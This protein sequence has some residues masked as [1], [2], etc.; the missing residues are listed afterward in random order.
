MNPVFDESFLKRFNTLA[1]PLA[2][3]W[4]MSTL[5]GIFLSKAPVEGA[6]ERFETF[7]ELFRFGDKFGIVTQTAGASHGKTVTTTTLVPSGH[8]VKAIY[9]S[10]F[11]S[12]VSI[13]DGKETTVVPLHGRYKKDFTLIGIS[14]S[15]AVFSGFGKSYRL[16]LGFEDNLARRKTVSVMVEETAADT[17]ESEWR[18]VSRE[19]LV[20]QM[21]NMNRLD[22]HIDLE[23]LRAGDRVN[24]FRVERIAAE[25]VLARLG[26]VQGDIIVSVNNKKLESYGDALAVY[27]Q[28]PQMRNIRITVLR[29]NLHKDLLYEITR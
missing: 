22:K 7:F 14:D 13:S 18:T 12:Y 20:E 1:L 4:S 29:N 28:V 25:S 2:L 9:R 23:I 19:V 8:R 3:V 21:Q 26:I 17:R 5:G 6:A 15:A 16:R 10:A 11:A 24:G 27:R